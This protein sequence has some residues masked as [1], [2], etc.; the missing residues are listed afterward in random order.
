MKHIGSKLRDLFALLLI[1]AV[2]WMAGYD[3][4]DRKH[5]K[6]CWWIHDL[7]KGPTVWRSTYWFT[8]QVG[9]MYEAQATAVSTNK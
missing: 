6:D 2:A 3:F 7:V 5:G 8:N 9:V 1:L 4:G